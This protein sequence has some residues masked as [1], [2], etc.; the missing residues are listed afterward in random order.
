MRKVVSAGFR[1]GKVSG[2]EAHVRELARQVIDRVARRGECDF[3]SEVAAELPLLVLA[4]LLGVPVEDRVK[5]FDWSN[6]LIGV[7]DPEVGSPS[8]ARVASF[9]M[10]MYA[11]DLFAKREKEPR[12]D[13]CSAL[14]HGEIDGEKLSAQER[15]MFFFLLVVAGNET[16]RNAISGGMLAL[17]EHPEQRARLL[18]DRALLRPAVDEIVR[19]VT[20]VMQFRRTA[21]RDTTLGGQSIRENDKVVIYYGSANRDGTVFEDPHTFDIGRD[22]NPHVGFGIGSHFCLGAHLARL[23]MRAMF[24]EILGRIPD[25]EVA[26]P[27]ERLRSN[28]I[29]GIK[30]MPVHFTAESG[31]T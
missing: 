14:V 5:L 20:P 15:C 24:D 30:S 16:T 4:E 28:F 9:E 11:A 17:C 26:G 22:P 29:N 25:V 7:D 3:V 18:A 10:I 1:P 8:D 27:V 31:G 2:M 23:E 19:W 12:D 13:L 21:T 6:R